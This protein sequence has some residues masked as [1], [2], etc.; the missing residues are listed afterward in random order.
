VWAI[1][2]VQAMP[3]RLTPLRQAARVLKPGG[4]LV[5]VD[6]LEQQKPTAVSPMREAADKLDA[7]GSWEQPQPRLQPIR[8]ADYPAL[9]EAAGLVPVELLDI[10]ANTVPRTFTCMRQRMSDD[11]EVL[12]DKFGGPIIELYETILPLFEAAGWGYGLIVATVAHA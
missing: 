4:R 11:R 9:L 6:V 12:V 5:V 7:H 2:S 1:E 8:M 10:S 3:D